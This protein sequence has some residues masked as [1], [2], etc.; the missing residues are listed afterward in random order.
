MR[1]GSPLCIASCSAWTIQTIDRMVMNGA[2]AG[3][4]QSNQVVE[5]VVS[6]RTAKAH[7]VNLKLS[8]AS[9]LLTPPAV[10]FENFLAKCSVGIKSQLNSRTPRL[11]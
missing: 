5:V 8:R 3:G 1:L 2:V 4:T 7:V 10:S 9:A 6:K 11:D